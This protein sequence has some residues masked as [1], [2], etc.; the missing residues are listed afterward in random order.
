MSET[1]N[2]ALDKALLLLE[3][4]AECG[5]FDGQIRQ[6]I[7]R[8]IL[9]TTTKDFMNSKDGYP[10][11]TKQFTV[12]TKVEDF[13]QYFLNML[14]MQIHDY[15]NQIDG[16]EDGVLKLSKDTK[17][18][19]VDVGPFKGK[20]Y[21]YPWNKI[22]V[23]NAG[24]NNGGIF[25]DMQVSPFLNVDMRGN[26]EPTDNLNPLTRTGLIYESVITLTSTGKKIQTRPKAIAFTRQQMEELGYPEDRLAYETRTTFAGM[27]VDHTTHISSMGMDIAESTKGVRS[28]VG[29]PYF[30]GLQLGELGKPI[31]EF[32]TAYGKKSQSYYFWWRLYNTKPTRSTVF[33]QSAMS[34]SYPLSMDNKV[35]VNDGSI[36]GFSHGVFTVNFMA[37]E[38]AR[39]LAYMEEWPA[40]GKN[41]NA[42]KILNLESGETDPF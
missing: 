35:E 18:A 11:T 32:I 13:G 4:P 20:T 17:F 25:M 31:T 37:P 23:Y 5:P 2:D 36:D 10:V 29:V 24:D 26:P 39:L 6:K 41:L 21:W 28:F 30:N 3:L 9:I 7:T 19:T 40:Q 33:G 14:S 16:V 15:G 1:N 22:E 8:S 12:Q 27:K 38:T 34:G 42:G